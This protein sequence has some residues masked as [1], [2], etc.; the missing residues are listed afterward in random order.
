MKHETN[1]CWVNATVWSLTAFVTVAALSACPKGGGSIY[2]TGQDP[3]LNISPVS[4]VE[5]RSVTQAPP[6]LALL[7]CQTSD[8][9]ITHVLFPR[10]EWVS[11]KGRGIGFFDAGP[12]K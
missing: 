9:G 6:D 11:M 2:K 4:C 12:G 1:F 7:N 8:G 10:Q 5:D 3:T